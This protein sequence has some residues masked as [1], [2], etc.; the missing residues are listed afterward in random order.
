MIFISFL[1]LFSMADKEKKERIE[2]EKTI[3]QKLE[4]EAFILKEMLEKEKS[5]RTL[6]VKD[7]QN[8]TDHELKSQ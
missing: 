5:D 6:A 7:L 2:G 8:H 1:D 3:L 4:D